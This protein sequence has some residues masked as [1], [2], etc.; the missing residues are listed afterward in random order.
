M[1]SVAK[2]KCLASGSTLSFLKKLICACAPLIGVDCDVF[3]PFS[4]GNMLFFFSL[5]IVFMS[6]STYIKHH[7]SI[8]DCGGC[9][10]AQAY[11]NRSTAK[12]GFAILC[13]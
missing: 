11:K 2:M 1:A 13:L 8:V 3:K 12:C 4:K 10:H 5:L 7:V 6:S 9:E